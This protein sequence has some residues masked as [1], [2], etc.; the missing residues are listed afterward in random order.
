MKTPIT[1]S[2]KKPRTTSKSKAAEVAAPPVTTP[3]K[4][5]DVPEKTTTVKPTATVKSPASSPATV[6]KKT[7]AT[8]AKPRKSQKPAE[9][10]AVS[11]SATPAPAV[12]GGEPTPPSR[13][14]PSQESINRMVEEAAY[15]LAEQRNFAPGFE[16]EDWLQAKQQ[17]MAQL[18]KADNPAQ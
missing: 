15:Y 8:P 14:I 11:S 2:E 1:T 7:A 17:I 16:E 9:P 18:A 3:A 13:P 6:A 5:A 12:A 4:P 10:L